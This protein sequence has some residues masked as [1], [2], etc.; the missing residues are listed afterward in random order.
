MK[1]QTDW[2][3]KQDSQ[4]LSLQAYFFLA[5]CFMHNSKDSI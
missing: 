1:I 5:Y 4:I 3:E 2:A